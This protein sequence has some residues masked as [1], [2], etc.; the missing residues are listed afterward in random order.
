MNALLLSNLIVTAFLTGLIWYVQISHYPGFENV[1]ENFTTYHHFHTSSTRKVVALPML[2]E[3][4]ISFVMLFYKD[5]SFPT[6]LK[7][8]AFSLVCIIW[9]LT[10]C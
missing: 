7:W 8:L 3:L 6:S 9:V 5:E 2:I 10:A 4:V 1:T